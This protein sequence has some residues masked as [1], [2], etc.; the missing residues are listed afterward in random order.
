MMY[1]YRYRIIK[2]GFSSPFARA[3][4]L[5]A[6]SIAAPDAQADSFE[7]AGRWLTP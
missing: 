6:G 1:A 5:L 3:R 4:K 7:G 2:T